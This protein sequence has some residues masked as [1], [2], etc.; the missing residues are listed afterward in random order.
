VAIFTCISA[1]PVNAPSLSVYHRLNFLEIKQLASNLLE[2]LIY[3]QSLN[4]P[5]FHRDIKP[6]NILVNDDTGSVTLVDFGLAKLGNQELSASTVVS[7]TAGFMPPEQLLNRRLTEASD[8]YSLG[9]TLICA[10]ANIK[11]TQLP[12]FVDETFAID[13]KKLLHT[14]LDSSFQWWL[15]KMVAP[16]ISDRFPNAKAA[17]KALEEGKIELADRN[18]RPSYSP[19]WKTVAVISLTSS[20][21]L[22]VI[23]GVGIGVYKAYQN[24]GADSVSISHSHVEQ[25]PIDRYPIIT[26]K[27]LVKKENSDLK[28]I[29]SLSKI[30]ID[31]VGIIYILVI[32]IEGIKCLKRGAS[33]EAVVEGVLK[34]ALVYVF[35]TLVLST[36]M[37]LVF[38]SN[39]NGVS[40]ERQTAKPTSV[41][42]DK[43]PPAFSSATEK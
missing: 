29:I 22:G 35:L 39:N 9:A 26:H 17:L 24:F 21:S 4:P 18:V 16:R 40:E 28:D 12:E 2:I 13:V 33:L 23:G 11:S 14:S 41:A 25:T 19:S 32:L 38:P 1:V 34:P 27:K 10:V 6:D 43:L 30:I 3:L 15:S 36:A 42:L 7:G 20:L 37:N 8:L 31:T 5:I